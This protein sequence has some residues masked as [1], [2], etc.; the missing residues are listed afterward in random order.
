M[1]KI[2]IISSI[3]FIGLSIILFLSFNHLNN[4]NTNLS[5]QT[6][7]LSSIQDFNIEKNLEPTSIVE[8]TTTSKL[9]L[10]DVRKTE[11][12]NRINEYGKQEKGIPVLMYHFFYDSSA[13]KV[14]TDNNFIEISKFEEHLKYLKNNDFFF[15]TFEE[16]S[17]FIAGEL[18][19]P[20]KSVIITVDDGNITF[21]TL[22]AP[23]IE[24][25]EIPVT[26]FVITS[27]CN[28]M[29]ES[30]YINFES[31]S[32]DL[33]KAGK[34]GKG[35]LVNLSYENSYKD[36]EHSISIVNSKE[37]FCYPFGHYNN[38][39]K[40]VL[41]DIGYK[42][43]FTTKGGSVKVGMDP[44]E[45]PRVRILRDDSLASFIAKVQN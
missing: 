15:P 41:K 8:N 1:K 18:E 25:Y 17:Q 21:F 39:A 44:F 16:L 20:K 34:N 10:E 5:L 14:D 4:K 45:L 35:L 22:A 29:Y 24:K 9:S 27:Q 40:Q 26:S 11:I 37:A 7:K 28:F 19:L 31:H 3:L 36:I 42:V 23:I 2:I 6:E 13:G 33:H 38:T 43:A 32:H 12:Q 30:D